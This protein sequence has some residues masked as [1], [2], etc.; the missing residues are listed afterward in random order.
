M[1]RASR[2]RPI[3]AERGSGHRRPL[4][5]SALIL[6]SLLISGPDRRLSCLGIVGLF[7][8]GE[9]RVKLPWYC[10]H[11]TFRTGFGLKPSLRWLRSTRVL[12]R[13]I[14][15]GRTRRRTRANLTFL[16]SDACRTAVGS[17]PR[18]SARASKLRLTGHTLS[19]PRHAGPPSPRR[20]ETGHTFATSRGFSG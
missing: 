10:R 17:F 1:H 19:L 6:K 5:C 4:S 7:S 12:R 2:R 9:R 20:R 11:R 14:G 13:L 8:V 15:P 18:A 3:R 16:V